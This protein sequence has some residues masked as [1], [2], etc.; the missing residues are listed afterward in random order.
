[1]SQALTPQPPDPPAETDLGPD[2]II[3]IW[4]EDLC[5]DPD[6]RRYRGNR[7][8][9]AALRRAQKADDAYDVVAFH[10]LRGRLI[11]KG[12]WR[13][14]SDDV[15]ARVAIALAPIDRDA[16]SEE[17]RYRLGIG[18]ALGRACAEKE[19]DKPRVSEDR[20][21][22]MLNTDNPDHFLRLLR[23]CIG[24]LKRGAECVAPVV[25]IAEVMAAW[26]YPQSRAS[27]RRRIFIGYFENLV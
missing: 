26:H 7:R 24:L 17:P 18:R 22:L 15:F 11:D 3:R 2:A 19:G 14:H 12:G 1:M 23:G 10:I 4:H 25:D 8:D 9:R 13:R 6:D 20:V 27:V 21:R 5:G 16:V